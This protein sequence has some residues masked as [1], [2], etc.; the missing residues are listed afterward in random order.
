VLTGL[1]IILIV[2]LVGLPGA[3]ARRIKKDRLE[4]EQAAAWQKRTDE[5]MQRS[6]WYQQ[7][8]FDS[9]TALINAKRDYNEA[10]PF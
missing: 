4:A 8:G 3:I 2:A 1:I 10:H 7:L 5:I 9:E 6:L